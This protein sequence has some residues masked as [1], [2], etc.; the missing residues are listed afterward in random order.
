MPDDNFPKDDFKELTREELIGEP[1]TGD[2]KKFIEEKVEWAADKLKGAHKEVGKVIYGQDPLIDL[3]LA[4]MAAG[5]NLLAEGVPGLAKTLLVATLSKVMGLDFQ[6][7]QFTPDLMPPDIIGTEVQ[8]DEKDRKPGEKPFIFVPGPL[9]TQFLM[10]D[11]IN[12]TGP[13]TQAALLQ[14]MQERK[15]TV[16]G[17]TYYLDNPFITMATQNPL[18]ND[19]TYPLPEAQ[20]DRFLIK[21]P[22]DYPDR[23]AEK[24]IILETTTTTT[25]AVRDLFNR[26]GNGE[27]LRKPEN[28]RRVEQHQKVEAILGTQDLIAMQELTRRL[29]LSEDVVD[30]ILHTVR[31]ARPTGDSSE[32]IQKNVKWGPGPRASQAFALVAK[33]QALMRGELSPT[34]DDIRELMTPVM[35]HRMA[36]KYDA[37]A[38]DVDFAAVLNHLKLKL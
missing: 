15:V 19:G 29:P 20:L 25:Q 23:D 28:Y 36:L 3:F 33:A 8:K 26:I 24:R 6:R 31:G 2:D 34:I 38:R 5:G 22:F 27:D 9:F 32:F 4:D 30:A 10:A 17:H 11:E 37:R 1:L 13:R 16:N 12:R 21:V 35:E 18:E 14:A 7:V